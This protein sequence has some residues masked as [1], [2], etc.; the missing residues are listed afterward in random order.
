MLQVIGLCRFSYPTFNGQGFK[1]PLKYNNTQLRY[2]LNL[3]EKIC[4][5]S[6]VSQTDHRFVLVILVGENMPYL[7]ELRRLVRNRNQIVIF[8]QP[9]HLPHLEAC[10]RAMNEYRKDRATHI[11]EFCMDDDDAVHKTFIEKTRNIFR[12]VKPMLDDG[13]PVELDFCRGFAARYDENSLTLKHVVMP[14][15]TPAQVIFQLA[16]SKK[17]IFAFNHY[18]FWRNRTCVSVGESP[19]FVRTFHGHN[20]SGTKWENMLHEGGCGDPRKILSEEFGIGD[21]RAAFG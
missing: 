15:W 9:E 4:L 10:A 1:E 19:M 11:A 20:D 12:I 16:S 7:G 21:I 13:S 5:P 6:I 2:R 8:K 3:F 14:H 17:N 18:R